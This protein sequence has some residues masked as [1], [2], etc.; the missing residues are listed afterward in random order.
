MKAYLDTNIISAIAKRDASPRELV[1]IE[2]LRDLFNSGKIKLTRSDVCKAEIDKIPEKFRRDHEKI[3]KQILDVPVADYLALD[4][5]FMPGSLG[6]KQNT[7]FKRLLEILKDKE[8]AKHILHA[9]KNSVFKFITLDRR[10]ILSRKTEIYSICNVEVLLP[11]EIIGQIKT[12]G[13]TQPDR[14]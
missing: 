9:H 10:T 3:Y 11:S 2:Q 12:G 4:L 13:L 7:I 6:V 1:A 14:A 8:D 5:F